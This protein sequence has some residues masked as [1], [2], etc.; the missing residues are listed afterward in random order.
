MIKFFTIIFY[1]LFITISA[2]E[3]GQ[4]EITTEEGIEVYQKEKFYLLKKN[5]IIDSDNFNLKAQ[6]VK[7]FF[8]EDLYDIEKINSEGNVTLTSS[9][10]LRA[11]G[12]KIDFE[13]KTENIVIVGINSKLITNDFNMQSNELIDVNNFS[14]NFTIIGEKSKITT[15]EIFITGNKI[16]G[17][18]L[19]ENGENIIEKMHVEDKKEI[20]IKTE[21][22]NM[23]AIS[24]DLLR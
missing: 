22:L 23:F 1:F 24:A 8:N 9:T 21:T 15:S 5:V 2:R 4:T 16:T 18:F 7:A 10:G 12:N 19:N 17:S 11:S 13:V 14:K 20:N 6:I 3:I